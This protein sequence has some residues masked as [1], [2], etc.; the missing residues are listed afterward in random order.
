MSVYWLSDIVKSFH[1][2]LIPTVTL[3]LKRI[4]SILQ[5]RKLRL[6]ELMS[7]APN[8]KVGKA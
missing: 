7:L 3:E 1:F 2:L 6:G 5:R 8:H 4:T